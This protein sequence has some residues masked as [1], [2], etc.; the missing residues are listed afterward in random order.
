MSIVINKKNMRRVV[1]TDVAPCGRIG[2]ST[3]HWVRVTFL[4]VIPMFSLFFFFLVLLLL[5]FFGLV[6]TSPSLQEPFV[7]PSLA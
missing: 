7:A 2:N 4:E 6:A 1:S 5:F 3:P